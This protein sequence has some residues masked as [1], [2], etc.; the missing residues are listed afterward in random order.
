MVRSA[1]LL[2]GLLVLVPGVIEFGWYDDGG[3]VTRIVRVEGCRLTY[4]LQWVVYK[5]V[6]RPQPF[7]NK[8]HAA[9]LM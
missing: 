8:I 7:T 3:A 5:V 4:E 6:E 9:A 1:L 2:C